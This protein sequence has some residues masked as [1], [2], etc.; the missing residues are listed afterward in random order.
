MNYAAARHFCLYLA[1]KNKLVDYYRSLKKNT[2]TNPYR[3]AVNL[4][5]VDEERFEQDWYDWVLSLK[6]K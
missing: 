1:Q 2:D 4:L 5:N 3:L 6:L